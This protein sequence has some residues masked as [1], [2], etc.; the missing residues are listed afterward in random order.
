MTNYNPWL[1]RFALGTAVA[2][3]VLLCFGGLVTSHGAGLAVPDWPNSY[4]YNM[5]LFPVSKWVGGIFYEH[6]HRLIASGVGFL[7]I[8]L[9]VWLWRQEQRAW[10]KWLGVAALVLVILQGVLGGLRVTLLRDEIGIVHATLAQFFFVLV[11]AIALF[12]SRWWRNPEQISA[13]ICQLQSFRYFVGLITVITLIQLTLGAAMRHQHA[14][15][16]I[17]DFPLA[18]GKAWPAMN[19]EALARYNQQRLEGSAQNPITASGVAL[20]MAHRLTAGLI[21]LGVVATVWRAR[22][23]ELR[24]PLLTKLSLGWLAL[25]GVQVS[26]GAFTIWSNKSA[27]VATA[28]VAVGALSLMMGAMIFL[29]SR[30]HQN[31]QMANAAT[32]PSEQPSASAFVATGTLR[33]APN[34]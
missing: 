16:A 34:C 10:L 9:A 24:D 17:P 12:T 1:H 21:F 14:G 26:L 23:K 15:L 19:P 3:L 33:S 4:G 25:I 5:F 6:T 2:T 22:R 7:T 31:F 30:R 18:Y 11:S 20:Q 29:V 13:E 8:I 32:S 27:D 28:H